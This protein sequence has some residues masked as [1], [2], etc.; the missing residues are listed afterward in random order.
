MIKLKSYEAPVSIPAQPPEAAKAPAPKRRRRR[1]SPRPLV[2]AI[3]FRA[4]IQG[5]RAVA[6]LLVVG[7]HA[8]IGAIGGGYVGVDIFFVISG[9]LITGLLFRELETTGR[10]SL[11]RFYSRRMTRLL[12]ASTVV[13]LGTLA[14]AW[15]WMP[16]LSLRAIAEDA[17]SSATYSLNYRL[18]IQ[19]TDYL[20]ALREPSPLQHFWSLAV[21]EQFY[22]VWPLLLI[23]FSLAWARRGKPSVAAVVT[24]LVL[25]SGVS[26]ALC[27]W[28]S[29]RN[30]PWAYFG[31]HTRA[32]ELGVGALIA[33][34]AHGLVRLW[35]SFA[36]VLTWAGLA[37]IAAAA[38]LYTDNTV[39]PGYAA[40]LPVAAAG[41]VIAGG[42]AH[43]SWGA[44]RLL[45]LKPMQ[46]LGRLSYSWYL[47]HWPV[48]IIAPYVLGHQPDVLTKLGLMVATLVP[49][50]MSLAAVE[51][52]IRFHRVFRVRPSLGLALGFSLTAGAVTIA[53]VAQVM[54]LPVVKGVRTATVTSTVLK[55]RTVSAD[56]LVRLVR[57]SAAATK[58]P[59]NLEPSL[60]AS[61]SDFPNDGNCIAESEV[62]SI[63]Y[64]IG[65]GCEKRGFAA[66][67]AQV[68][69]FGDS[70]AQ[71][72][73]D[74][75]NV[76]AQ[77]RHWRLVVYTKAGCTPAEAEFMKG[78]SRTPYAECEQWR[79]DA[80]RRIGKL[81]PEMVV[82]STIQRSDNPLGATGDPE[83]AW[84]NAWLSTAKKLKRSGAVPVII[85]DTPVPKD[86]VPECLSGHPAR[87]R[88]CNLK[89]A[90]ALSVTRQR[91][92]RTMAKRNGV[93]V[94]ETTPWF[95]T[96]TVC[97]AIIGNTVV[98]R[99][100]SHITATYSTLLGG[101]LG[102]SLAG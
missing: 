54:P 56:Q 77:A 34:G 50:S 17:L 57:T 65:A 39:F 84:A 45:G 90:D 14:A 67:T 3:G 97:P 58:L 29:T 68:V 61:E 81:R 74:A 18:A 63:S 24:G 15:H 43:P 35:K 52:Q 9:F 99:D 72:W 87:I 27:V 38:L 20:G 86:N 23:V 36:A 71:H 98:Y 92:I 64:N 44:Q 7:Y 46:E 21:E 6:V 78:D 5:L 8:G 48:L 11:S 13:V 85:Q 62:R 40:L 41:L 10:I 102:K 16:P 94:V 75:L 30:L 100:K 80:L 101:L 70:H 96:A 73:Y 51:N 31:I 66:G 82:M 42:C 60:T 26:L 93:R 22:L 69:L 28:Q 33:L 25:L 79:A 59:S 2:R 89:P 76:V 91:A 32:W 47:W 49:A 55:S 1:P 88:L 95:C 19:N 37:G 4:D 83:T 12:P 53:L